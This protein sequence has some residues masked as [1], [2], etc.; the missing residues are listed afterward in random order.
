L[1]R[2]ASQRSL[3]RS[4]CFSRVAEN[5]RRFPEARNKPLGCAA[6]KEKPTGES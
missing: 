6:E 2:A 1:K 4:S 5:R 3:Q